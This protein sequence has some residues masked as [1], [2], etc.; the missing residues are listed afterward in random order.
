MS[1]FTVLVTL[2]DDITEEETT[3]LSLSTADEQ[4]A[5]SLAGHLGLEAEEFCRSGN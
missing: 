2:R 5:Y 4:L 1:L 3:V